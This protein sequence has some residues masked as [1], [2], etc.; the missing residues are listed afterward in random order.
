MS[1]D[2]RNLPFVA[3]MRTRSIGLATWTKN[4]P[5]ALVAT[6]GADRRPRRVATGGWNGMRGTASSS[7]AST[8]I[9]EQQETGSESRAHARVSQVAILGIFNSHGSRI[10]QGVQECSGKRRAPGEQSC[11]PSAFDEGR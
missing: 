8:E 5:L 7:Q 2:I 10:D 11:H 6:N 4:Q 1:R 3:G 9:V